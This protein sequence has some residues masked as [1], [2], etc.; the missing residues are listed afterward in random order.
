MSS[1]NAIRDQNFIPSALAVL[2]TDTV[3]GT[4][5]VRI[6]ANESNSGMKI[7][8]TSTISF[9]MQPIDEQDENYVDCMTFT[10]SDGLLYPWVADSDGKVLISI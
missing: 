9:T 7:N 4:N 10:G 3:Q 1:E 6:K 5:N 2:N 8:T